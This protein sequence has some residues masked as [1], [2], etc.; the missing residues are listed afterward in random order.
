MNVKELKWHIRN[1]LIRTDYFKIPMHKKTPAP[2]DKYKF[3]F[4]WIDVPGFS[5]RQYLNFRNKS[6]NSYMAVASSSYPGYEVINDYRTLGRL[7]G[8]KVYLGDKYLCS[9][10][11][12]GF[13][14]ANPGYDEIQSFTTYTDSY[15]YTFYRAI[16]SRTRQYRPDL[17]MYYSLTNNINDVYSCSGSVYPYNHTLADAAIT[18]YKAVVGMDGYS[19][20]KARYFQETP[21]QL[22][23]WQ[24]GEKNVDLILTDV[25]AWTGT[26]I[27]VECTRLINTSESGYSITDENDRILPDSPFTATYQNSDT[28]SVS[29][30]YR[31]IEQFLNDSQVEDWTGTL[32]SGTNRVNYLYFENTDRNEFRDFYFDIFKR[33]SDI[34][35]A[36]ENWGD[37]NA[38]IF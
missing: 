23:Y 4:T 15:D 2:S 24:N 38:R 7:F 10:I 14:A 13:S 26:S 33:S 20:K 29:I 3:V 19:G 21:S 6:L 34:I 1:G 12:P 17:T 28:Y 8:V 9:A 25:S 37:I 5:N 27:D 32:P 35:I 16:E 30:P 11:I 31:A 22:A 18:G 36:V